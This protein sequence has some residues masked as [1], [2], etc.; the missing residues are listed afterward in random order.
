MKRVLQDPFRS[1]EEPTKMEKL[2]LTHMKLEILE[3]NIAEQIK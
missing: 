3:I 1:S 2:T